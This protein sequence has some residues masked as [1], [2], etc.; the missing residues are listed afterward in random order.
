MA[1]DIL[2]V[3]AA[4][5]TNPGM[6]LALLDENLPSLLQSRYATGLGSVNLHQASN[7]SRGSC[8]LSSF[9]LIYSICC[10]QTIYTHVHICIPLV[11]RAGAK[12]IMIIRRV[13]LDSTTDSAT[14]PLLTTSPRSYE[15]IRHMHFRDALCGNPCSV[16]FGCHLFSSL[17][18]QGNIDVSYISE[19]N[20]EGQRQVDA[21]A[22][23]PEHASA[24]VLFVW[25]VSMVIEPTVV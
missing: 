1:A 24:G 23:M 16:S 12:A 6:S 7:L 2:S 21:W 22:L 3:L 15:L 14:T 18:P 10:P 20:S 17:L 9:P 4:R 8:T 25:R 13:G 5:A 19:G 11:R